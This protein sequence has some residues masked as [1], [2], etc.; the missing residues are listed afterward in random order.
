MLLDK[1]SDKRYELTALRFAR[2]VLTSEDLVRLFWI[3]GS[4]CAGCRRRMR[5][6]QNRRV[7]VT[8]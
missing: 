5:S 6:D 3:S 2:Q 4:T 8:T 1:D 7:A